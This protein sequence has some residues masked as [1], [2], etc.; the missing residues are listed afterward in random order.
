MRCVQRIGLVV[1]MSAFEE[2]G[3]EAGDRIEHG[4]VIPIELVGAL[5][6]LGLIVVTQPAFVAR[7]GDRY[8]R[9]HP[10]EEQSDL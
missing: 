10:A 1:A 5:R 3:V 7:R 9:E 6:D 2:V 8:L 4:A